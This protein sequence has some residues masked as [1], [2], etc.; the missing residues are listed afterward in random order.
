MAKLVKFNPNHDGLGR[1]TFTRSAGDGGGTPNAGSKGGGSKKAKAKPK[2]KAKAKDKASEEEIIDSKTKKIMGLVTRD[3]GKETAKRLEPIV[4]EAFR[5]QLSGDIRKPLV[6]NGNKVTNQGRDVTALDYL[7]SLADKFGVEAVTGISSESFASG[8]AFRIDKHEKHDQKSHAG[9]KGKTSGSK[10]KPKNRK[11]KM[12]RD[13]GA[14][15][16]SEIDLKEAT[17]DSLEKANPYKD[18][19]GRF[20]SANNAVAPKSGRK[21]APTR[22]QSTMQKKGGFTYD[23]RTNRLKRVG[24]AVSTDKSAETVTTESDFAKNGVSMVKKFLFEQRERLG[25]AKQYLGGWV[26]RGKVYLDISTVVK[27]AQE[28]ADL[29]RKHDQIAFF[30]LATFT[31]HTRFKTTAGYK[32]LASGSQTSGSRPIVGE[33]PRL[34]YGEDVRSVGKAE[35]VEGVIL[36]PVES[37][38]DD[39]S[40]QRF[41]E[42]VMATSKIS[43]GEPTSSDVHL[44]TIMNNKKRKKKTKKMMLSEIVE[45]K[46]KLKNPKG[47]LTAAGRAHFNRTTGSKLKAGVK[48]KADT[49]EKMR[50]KGSFLT[51]F[52]TNP[53]GPMKDDKGRPTRLALSANAWGEPVPQDRAAAARLAEKGRNLLERYENK[54]KLSKFNP[55]HDSIGR[56]TFTRSAGDSGGGG[57]K[58]AYLPRTQADIDAQVVNRALKRGK[59]RAKGAEEAQKIIDS[60]ETQPTPSSLADAMK[61]IKVKNGKVFWNN[62]FDKE[63]M[64]KMV[65]ESEQRVRD[66]STGKTTPKSVEAKSKKQALEFETETLQETRSRLAAIIETESKKSP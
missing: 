18:E 47:G 25:L 6:V 22:L 19:M 8:D 28:A 1:F 60:P 59:D 46:A 42:Q 11:K 52:F 39:Q 5:Q 65:T 44:P 16:R 23:A 40:I 38:T 27:T 48:G 58:P 43:K 55:N 7:D 32:Y 57:N 2:A 31:T 30:D 29:G 36:Y 63:Y 15:F 21:N 14:T 53:S 12:S 33:V 9:S 51:R 50:R 62:V 37:L 3:A 13:W 4:R 35:K 17:R 64:T 20:T 49:P 56:F 24:F 45:K 66:I 26:E 54:K 41:V 34:G 10:K 61:R